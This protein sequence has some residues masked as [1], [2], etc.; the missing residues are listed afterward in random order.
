MLPTFR[1][2]APNIYEPL[3][4]LL[5]TRLPPSLVSR[6]GNLYEVLSRTPGGGIGNAVHQCRWTDKDIRNSYWIVTRSQFKCGG[7]HGKAW[8]L[9]YWKGNLVSPQEER[10]RGALKYAWRDGPSQPAKQPSK[11]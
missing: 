3:K 6:S 11:S 9:L 7:K 5:P 2:C 1:T 4:K 8:G 10:I